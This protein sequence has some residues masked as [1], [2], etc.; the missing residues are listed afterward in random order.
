[1]WVPQPVQAWRWITAALSTIFSL[2]PFSS[3][4]TFSRGTTAT[5]EKVAPDGFQHLVQ[6]QAW[7]WATS[8]LTPTLTFLSAHLQTSVPPAKLPEPCLTPLSTDGWI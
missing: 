6:P 4:V 1:M 5:T 7:L 2:S 8:P 3:T